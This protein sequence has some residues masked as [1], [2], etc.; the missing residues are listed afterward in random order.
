MLKELDIEKNVELTRYKRRLARLKEQLNNLVT[1]FNEMDEKD[2]KTNSDLTEDYR[3]LTQKYKDLQA[4]F[5]HFELSD[6]AKFEEVWGM[7]EDEA[8]E[9][10]DQLLK[11]DKIIS[12]Q[13]LGWVWKAPDM[14]LLQGALT[15]PGQQPAALPGDAAVSGVAEDRMGSGSPPDTA[16]SVSAALAGGAL[17]GSSSVNGLAQ[18]SPAMAATIPV[19]LRSSAPLAGTVTVSGARIRAV[20]RLLASEAGFLLNTQVE[21]TAPSMSVTTA[22]YTVR[23]LWLCSIVRPLHHVEAI[24]YPEYVFVLCLFAIQ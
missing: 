13:Q 24:S 19:G 1:R 8:K 20:L 17:G 21:T 4:K 3:R 9:M 16:D 7:H 23:S 2:S 5:R 12:E 10:V 14:L 11:A 18:L 6:T 22:A 15:R